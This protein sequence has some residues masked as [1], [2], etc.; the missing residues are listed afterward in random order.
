[1]PYYVDVSHAAPWWTHLTYI[2]DTPIPKGARIKVPLGR[3]ERTAIVSE[4]KS[5]CGKENLK[6]ILKIID[7]KPIVPGDLSLLADW[8]AHTWFISEGSAYKIVLPS[9]FFSDDAVLEPAA[10]DGTERPAGKFSVRVHDPSSCYSVDKEKRFQTYAEEIAAHKTEQVLVIF[11]EHSMAECFWK[12]LPKEMKASAALWPKTSAAAWKLWVKIRHGEINLVVGS[13]S[14]VF[15]PFSAA[16]LVIIDEENSSSWKIKQ[17]PYLNLRSV[18]AKRAFIAGAKLILGGSMPSLKSF[19]ALRPKY[20]DGDCSKKV[21]FVSSKDA[22]SASFS[23]IDG[24]LAISSALHR[25]TCLALKS[26][27]WA[28]WILDRKGYALNIKCGE[29][30]HVFLCAKCGALMRIESSSKIKC[31]S[32]GF[33]EEAPSLCPVC[34]SRLIAADR[35]GL[36]ALYERVKNTF[37]NV[38]LLDDRKPQ[39]ARDLIKEHQYG[40]LLIGTRQLLAYCDELTPSLIGWIDSYTAPYEL[41]WESMWRGNMDRRVV[42]QGTVPPY[43]LAAGWHSFLQKEASERADLSLPPFSFIVKITGTISVLEEI[44]EALD[45]SG[46]PYTFDNDI[47]V[48]TNH[49]GHLREILAPFFDIGRSRSAGGFPAV[50]ITT[51]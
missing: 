48:Y 25:E 46:E 14:A 43:A 24:K 15:A 36:S 1:M 22:R 19:I 21:I 2:S 30:G 9:K 50:L 33:T 32:C 31:I 39:K 35:P 4:C 17:H 23:G 42:I 37:K 3:S 5:Y 49:F 8:I 18:A 40:G 45:Q 12:W 51:E 20:S 11:P 13:H 44:K 38:I 16:A 41:F 27:R 26:G 28:F 6:P 7:E 29:C 34:G 10:P 47:F